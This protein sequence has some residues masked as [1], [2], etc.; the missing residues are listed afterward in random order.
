VKYTAF[1]SVAASL[2]ALVIAWSFQPKGVWTSPLPTNPVPVVG[3]NVTAA[4]RRSRQRQG[5]RRST[6]DCERETA[7]TLDVA[8]AHLRTR[9]QVPARWPTLLM[10]P[11]RFRSHSPGP[12]DQCRLSGI[13]ASVRRT[14]ASSSRT[15]KRQTNTDNMLHVRD[16]TGASI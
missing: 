12:S 1:G 11:R 5:G 15:N 10:P 14:V 8:H 2:T 9:A 13:N 4:E 3:S 7:H 6:Y 16:L